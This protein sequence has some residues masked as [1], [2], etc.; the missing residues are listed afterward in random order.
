MERFIRDV[1]GFKP[2]DIGLYLLAVTHSSAIQ[3][4]S[5]GDKISN[6]RLEYLG[7]AVIDLVVAE[8]LYKRFPT[9]TEGELTQMKSKVVSRQALNEI[10]SKI[11]LHEYIITGSGLSA[12]RDSLLGNAFEA[13]AGA[14]YLDQG[15]AF[16]KR[17]LLSL[18]SKT[19]VNER[20]K[21]E[22]DYKSKLNT[23]CQKE[24]K[25][26]AFRVEEEKRD[27]GNTLYTIAAVIDG[28]ALGTGQGKSKKEAEQSASKNAWSRL[29]NEEKSA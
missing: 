24:Y 19:R 21:E 27:Q 17:K 22:V 29:F 28:N 12:V 16:T 15:F 4:S 14:M 9:A 11:G 13:L 1:F 10:G 23:W 25:K 20:I 8:F 2:G 18:L 5:K 3:K 6:E 7:D 26:L